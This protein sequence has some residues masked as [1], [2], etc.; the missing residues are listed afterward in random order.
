MPTVKTHAR[1]HL[2]CT[3]QAGGKEEAASTRRG[4]GALTWLGR[5]AVAARRACVRGAAGLGRRQRP[6]GCGREDLI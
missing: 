4:S 2:Q 6:H 1:H 3:S 5:R